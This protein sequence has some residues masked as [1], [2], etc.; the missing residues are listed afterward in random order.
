VIARDFSLVV[1]RSSGL[2]DDDV[3]GGC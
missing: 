1:S 2:L 3:G